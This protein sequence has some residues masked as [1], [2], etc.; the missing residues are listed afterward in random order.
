MHSPFSAILIPVSAILVPRPSALSCKMSHLV[1]VVTLH[2]RNKM[3]KA[4]PLSVKSSYCQKKFPLLVRKVPPAE[5]KRCHSQEDCTAIEDREMDQQ[6][7]TLAK[8]TIL[9]I[10]KFKQ[11]PFRIQQFLQHEYYAL[12]EVIEF[13]DS[14][15]APKDEVATGSTTEGTGK[16]KGR[17]V[18][19]TTKYMQKRRNDVKARTTL[20]LALPDE[21]QLRFNKYKTAQELWAASLKTFGGNEATKKTK[22]N[23]LKQHEKEEVNTASIPTAST[24]V[25]PTSAN[26]RV[27]SI[28]QDTACAYIASQSNGSKIKFEYI[29]QIDEDDIEE[30]DIKWNMALLSMRADRYWKRTGKKI[31]IQG[32]YVVGF[33]KSKVECF[34]CHKMGHFARDCR[35]P[36]SQDRGR[37]D[38]YK[39]GS[40]VEEEAP[41]DL[42]AI[43]GVG[44]DWS[45]ME[46]E[47]ENHALVADEEAPTEFALMAKTCVEFEVKARLVEFKNQEVKYCKKIRCLE[48]K[49]KSRANRIESLTNEI[50]LLKKEKEGLDSKLT[51]FQTASKDLD[52]LLESQ[53]S[54]KNK[55]GLGYND[56][57]TDYSRPSPAIESTS[58][59]LQNRNPSV[60]KTGASPSNIVSK[61]FVKF[62]KAT[63]SPTEN[64]VDKDETVRK[65]TVKYAE[66]YRKTSKKSN[67]RGN[68]RNWNNLKSQQLGKNFVMKK[69][70]YNCSSADHLSY[71]C[72]KW[73]DHGRTW[74]KNSNTH[75]SRTPRTVFH[76]PGRPP[77][78]TNRPYMNAAQPKRTSF[79]KP[80]HL[81]NKGL[82]KEHQQKFPTGNTKF[83]TADI[84]FG[85]DAVE[86]IKENTKCVNATDEE[87][88]AAKHK[89]LNKGLLQVV[90]E[91]FGELLLMKNSFQHVHILY[92]FCFHGFSKSSVILNGDSPV[93][94]RIV[95]GVVQP[96]APTTAEQKLA[97][98]KRFGGNTETKKV[99]KTLL[100][101]QF[102]KFSGSSSE[103]LDQIH[104]RLQ[105]L[106]SQL[107]IHRVSLSQKDVNLKFLRSLPSE[108]KT[109][110]LIWRNKTDL[111]DKNLDDL[112]KSLKIYESKVKHSSSTGTD[113]HN[114]AFVSSTPTDSTT[115]SVSAA[116]NVFDVGI[117]LTAST[118]PNVDSLSNAMAMLTMR[119]RRFLQKTGQNL[120][121]NGPTSTCF[122]M[123]KVECY[124]CHRKGHFARE[125]RSPKDSRRTA[126]A[127]PPRR[128]VPKARLGYNSQV[129]IKAMFDCDNYYSSKSDC[130][131]WPPSN[132]YDR[133]SA[134]IIKDWVFESEEDNMPQVS[135]DLPSFAQSFKL[136][137]SPRHSGQLF[138]APILVVPTI[139]LR[140]KP[141]SKGSRRTKKACFVFKSVDHLIKDCDFHA[142]KLAH[143]PYASRDIH[144]QYAPVNHSNSPL[145][146]VT[147][148]AP[149]Q[150]QSVLTTVARSV[151][152]VKPTFSMTRP[153]LAF[154]VVSKSKS[155]LRR[156]LPRRPSSNPSNSPPRVT[157]AKA[158]VVSTAQDK[159][160]FGDYH[161]MIAILEKYEH[162]QD[163]HQIVDF[164]EAS[165]IRYALTFNPNVYVSHIRQFWSTARIE[166]T[167]EGTK[168][169]ATVDGRSNIATAL[170]CLATNRV[171]NFSKMIFDGMVKNVNNKVSKFLM[172][173]RFLSK[174]LKMGHFGQITNTHTYVVPFHTRKICN[175]LR[176]NNPSF[177]GRTVPLFS[178][179]LVTMGEGSGTPT[180][181]HHTPSLEAQQTS[182]TT[183][184]S[185]SLPPVTTE[186][187]P[188]I[189]PSV[190]LQLRQYTIRARI[191]Q[192]SA[193]PTTA[194]E[195][196]S[197]LRNGIQGEACPTVTGLIRLLE[198]R[199]GGGI[200]HSGEDAPIKGRS[201]DEGE[202]AT[203]ERSTERGSDDTKEMVNVLN[204]LDAAKILTSGGVQ[205]SI[206]PAVEFAIATVS[207]PTGSGSIPTAS[208]PG[209]GV[210]TGNEMVPTASLIFTTATESTP[211]TRRK[212]KE[213]MVESDT[214]K[215]KKLQEQIDI[216]RDAEI[217]R[218][219]A[220]EELQMM[221]NGLDRNNET[222][223]KYLQ[224]YHHFATELPIGRRIQLISDLVKYQDNYAKVL[225]FQTQ[226]RKPLSRKRVRIAQ[227]S[228]LPTVADEP[229]SPVR[230]DG[231]GE[232]CPT[233]SGFIADQDRATITKSSTLPSDS[234]PRVTSP[235]AEDGSMQQ[236]LNELTD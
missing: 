9:D 217:A 67:V 115:N 136:V 65:T 57:V 149:S 160:A 144:K 157:T 172:Y 88:T 3:H 153:K 231:Q 102:E 33:D 132:L 120:G 145:H 192:S 126:I 204:S 44:W 168:I 181:P 42:M 82:F 70:C 79:Y 100:K 162:N 12:W 69:A 131:S 176:V 117:K 175:T 54:D 73:V 91:P 155:T 178:S 59:D 216:T 85:V 99:Q 195:P 165:H 111:E 206:S 210:L 36:K 219:H 230:D 218:I 182:P 40:K 196:A 53:R 139:P 60:T 96:V 72:G 109:H 8:I 164:V 135:K 213:K 211:Y 205:V 118:L 197:P 78:R 113:S 97:I 43:D 98:E 233:D 112:F 148:V 30:M 45:F 76:K 194:D 171:Y 94:T 152:A 173:P 17:T 151:S 48:F 55:E 225:K 146:M 50:E 156:H 89:S 147:T 106:V 80:T 114:L 28:S 1:A 27:A 226:Q 202:E 124:N 46:N 200:A 31:T 81:Y 140:S 116:V 235:A 77:M 215:K 68:Q 183:H 222:I 123:N 232:A 19:L 150:S 26:I 37:R 93:P 11:W 21:H 66:L 16:K 212:R 130:D 207:I 35:A 58:D 188:T 38:N 167:E 23:L 129:F 32:T 133:P 137:I 193:L 122:D 87:L 51:G 64:K 159:K 198:D 52:S 170:V 110:T 154:R 86:E 6:N 4:F 142:R 138:Q 127:E 63:D 121:A 177:S 190:T 22:E 108:W 125:C 163:F 223:A 15:K 187:L 208:P 191:A 13:R 29:N 186:P 7:P 107:E 18:A 185:P 74:A 199:E 203:A 101:Q 90:S 24:N 39:Q 141:H 49:V 34:N 174:C 161:N 189:T 229:A 201:L 158:S 84:A 143:R 179:M 221:I 71:N 119:A 228:A 234:A 5:D 224:E 209:T 95:K 128:N 14:Y 47:E 236:T 56:T 214:P 104:D 103:G 2:V 25:S 134:P 75:K 166:T 180:E 105:K 92:L 61:P 83:F 41:K 227:S 169:L 184:S 20:L 220:E 62:V 10:R